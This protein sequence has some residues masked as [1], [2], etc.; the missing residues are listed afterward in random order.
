MD[1]EQQMES[2][3]REMPLN[4]IPWNIEDPPALLV[5]LVREKTVLPCDAV[6]LGCGVGNYTTWLALQGFR[7]TGIDLSARAVELAGERARRLGADCTFRAADLRQGPGGL[8]GAFDFAFDW[9]VL[10]HVFPEDRAAYMWS[11]QRMLRPGGKYL[12]VCFSEQDPAF[13]G[14]AKYRT[15]PLGTVLYFTSESEARALLLK[16]FRIIE[17]GTVETEGK[18]GV[19]RSIAALVE[20]Q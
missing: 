17:L 4:E 13:G 12:S 3:Y 20:R 1:L 15:T 11:V 14:S 16:W 8:A 9:E 2:I 7:V 19:H 6:D 10:H 5:D 18:S